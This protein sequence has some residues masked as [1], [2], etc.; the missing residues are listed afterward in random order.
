[1]PIVFPVR[2]RYCERITSGIAH[3]AQGI[4][5]KFNKL[6]I[7]PDTRIRVSAILE[8]IITN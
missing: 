2:K 5:G 4:I 7:Q 1:M 6:P 3:V 8:I